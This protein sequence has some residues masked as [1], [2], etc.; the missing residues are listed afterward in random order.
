MKVI[1]ANESLPVPPGTPPNR[2]FVPP[3]L[4]GEVIDWAHRNKL[5]CHL[6]IRR[7]LFRLLE[8]FWWPEARR[9]VSDYIAACSVCSWQS[10]M[11][12]QLAS[13]SPCLC[14]NAPGRK[15]LDFVTGLPPSEG[16]TTI[17][18]VV[19]R[20][21]KMV[22]FIPMPKLPSAKQ[23]ANIMLTHVFR[24]FGF[25]RN[26]LS[27]WGP[28]FV[29]QFWG[30]FCQLVGATVSLSLGYHPQTNGQ[31]ER[32][33]QD[34]ETGLHCLT[35]ENP[36]AWSKMLPWI[37][38]AHN[39]LPSASTGLTPFQVVFGY[40]PPLFSAL[41]K[42]VSI[43]A[44][45]TMVRRCRGMWVRAWRS[46]LKTS[47]AYKRSADSHRRPA[48]VYR[49]GQRVWLSTKNLPLHHPSRR[50][51]PR[52]IGPFPV[53]KVIYK[54]AVKLQ[55][56]RS[57]RIHPTFHVSQVKPVKESPLISATKP[58]TTPPLPRRRDCLHS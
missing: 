19:D 50:L 23:T 53:S 7:T 43:P 32:L 12:R 51:A 48:P 1:K 34:L 42:E 18:T 20:F 38:Y 45:A 58:P 26:I 30:A 36:S 33:S 15:S 41:E 25:P 55:L 8:R 56:P 31:T 13:F 47:A 37:E 14:H 52:F 54:S 2:L 27:D 21:S 16:N 24:T 35:S 10:Q 17:L 44:A 40:Q 29:A 22:K 6:G 49:P 5:S 46:L 39:T 9:D 3:P 4:R 57:S 28:Q 11:P